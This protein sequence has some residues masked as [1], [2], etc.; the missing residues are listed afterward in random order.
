MNVQ[1][2]NPLFGFTKSL[3]CVDYLPKPKAAISLLPFLFPSPTESQ[4]T[5][6]KEAGK[7]TDRDFENGE[8][9]RGAVH[10]SFWAKE[11][12]DAAKSES[13]GSDERD[14]DSNRRE[15]RVFGPPAMQIG[16]R[17]NNNRAEERRR[18]WEIDGSRNWLAEDRF[19]S[20]FLQPTIVVRSRSDIVD[21]ITYPRDGRD[22]NPSTQGKAFSAV[23]HNLR[24]PRDDRQRCPE[25]RVP[26]GF[27]FVLPMRDSKGG[28]ASKG[29]SKGHQQRVDRPGNEPRRPRHSV[30][31]RDFHK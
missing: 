15:R 2:A 26:L 5:R 30:P 19:P 31:R 11:T 10:A 4:N 1:V 27:A 8:K 6:D 29:D 7:N 28:R 23:H 3:L 22:P 21:T 18:G 25:P 24:Q 16:E 14:A 13:A 17:A 12:D 9:Q 20:H